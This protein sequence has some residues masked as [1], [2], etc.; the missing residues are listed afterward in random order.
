M[1]RFPLSLLLLSSLLTGCYTQ[2][3]TRGHYSRGQE[4]PAYPPEAAPG[5]SAG[6]ASPG[7]AGSPAVDS[8]LAASPPHADTLAPPVGAPTVIVNNY[9]DPSPHYRGYA[10]WEWDYPLFSF[11][12]Y[13]SHYGRYSRPYWWDDP[14]YS[15]RPIHHRPH[16]HY[17]PD[18]GHAPTRPVAPSGPY[19]SE[20][21]LFNP[22]PAYQPVRKGRRS[23]KP[24]SAPAE[25]APAPKAG[26]S[27]G[28]DTSG[29]KAESGA[30]N[31]A[32][33]KPKQEEEKPAKEYRS[34]RKGR[35]Q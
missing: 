28:N 30:T 1:Q 21:R 6:L 27:T 20:K 25:T 22:D 7:A 35:R 33:A 17:R 13:S 29:A 16:G 15:R 19:Q 14:W 18:R 11:G 9:Y 5:D 23:E 8:A 34:L 4:V 26:S 32:E 2:L 24:V 31:A 12:Y 3:A 10:H